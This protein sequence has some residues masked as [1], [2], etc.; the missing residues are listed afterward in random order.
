MPEMNGAN[1][2]KEIDSDSY[3]REKS[4]PFIFFSIETSTEYIKKA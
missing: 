1:F 3:L 4:I 2:K